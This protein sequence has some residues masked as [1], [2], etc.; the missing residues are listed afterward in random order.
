M[1]YPP[2]RIIFHGCEQE[3]WVVEI[4]AINF[5][6]PKSHVLSDRKRVVFINSFSFHDLH[7]SVRPF[8]IISPEHEGIFFIRSPNFTKESVVNCFI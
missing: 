6:N 2:G 1:I 4:V 5:M 7:C 8:N 3:G